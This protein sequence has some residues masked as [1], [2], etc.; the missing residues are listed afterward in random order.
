[1]EGVLDDTLDEFDD[2]LD[3][4]LQTAGGIDGG[5]LGNEAEQPEEDQSH[6]DRPAQGVHMNRHEAHVGCLGTG[7]GQCPGRLFDDAAVGTLITCRR[8]EERR[9]GKECRSMW[10]ESELEIS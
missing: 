3:K 10:S 4:I 9:V 1:M 6:E 5:A 8:S 7:T 2:D